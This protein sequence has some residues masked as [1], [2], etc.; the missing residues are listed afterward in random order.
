ML[1]NVRVDLLKHEVE[2]K[3]E[4]K[5]EKRPEMRLNRKH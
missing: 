3:E 4:K 1:R 5:K 2:E